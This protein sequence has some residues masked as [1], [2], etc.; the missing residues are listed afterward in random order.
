MTQWLDYDTNSIEGIQI[1][2]LFAAIDDYFDNEGSSP[3][4]SCSPSST[5]T[6]GKTTNRGVPGLFLV[7]HS[8]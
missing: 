2:E 6:S 4:L 7:P 5:L 1:G 3:S 8:R